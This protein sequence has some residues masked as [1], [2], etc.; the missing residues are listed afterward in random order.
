[1]LSHWVH[2]QPCEGLDQCPIGFCKHLCSTT[3]ALAF[4]AAKVIMFLMV[5][6]WVSTCVPCVPTC[7]PV[8]LPVCVSVCVRACLRACVPACMRACVPACLRACLRA[9]HPV[10][11]ADPVLTR[12]LALFVCAQL[13][14]HR[15]LEARQL[16]PTVDQCGH[17]RCRHLFHLF[18]PLRARTLHQCS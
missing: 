17:V 3:I 6:V 12:P 4:C 11:C 5:S 15:F 9:C 16:F 8:C 18:H 13:R 14:G 1:M 7:L 10:T 2:A